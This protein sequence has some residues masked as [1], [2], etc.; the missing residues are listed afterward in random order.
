[1][2]DFFQTERRALWWGKL[3]YSWPF[4][5]ICLSII[6]LLGWYAFRSYQNYSLARAEYERIKEEIQETESRTAE[7]KKE[8]ALLEDEKGRDRILR[9]R[10]DVKKPGEEVVIIVE[11][12]PQPPTANEVSVF[13]SFKNFFKRLFG[14]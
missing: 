14:F 1:M 13:E 11:E 12:K 3:F 2:S 9:E 10:F 6:V 4:I 7:L 8:L 5:F